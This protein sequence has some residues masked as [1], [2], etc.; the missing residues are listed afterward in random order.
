MPEQLWPLILVVLLAGLVASSVP[1]LVTFDPSRPEGLFVA[2]VSE[3][4]GIRDLEASLRLIWEDQA[5]PVEAD[6]AWLRGEGAF[7]LEIKSPPE[8]AGQIFTYQGGQLNHY[9]PKTERGPGVVV[10]DLEELLSG[11]LNGPLPGPRFDPHALITALRLG[12][13]RATESKGD[14]IRLEV[15]GQFPGLG[16]L[17]RLALELAPPQGGPGLLLERLVSLTLY[18][19]GAQERRLKIDLAEVKIDQGLTLHQIRRFPQPYDWVLP[20]G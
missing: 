12:T 7:R 15:T 9:L 5:L 1:F 16:P 18:L 8:L 2:L 17:R 19:N 4:G 6:F 20:G 10:V 13:L 11:E 14:T 3:L